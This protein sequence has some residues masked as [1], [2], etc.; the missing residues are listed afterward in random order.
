M[1]K[2]NQP[3]CEVAQLRRRS[4]C[5]FLLLMALFCVMI[6]RLYGISNGTELAAAAQAQQ[7]YT[8]AVANTRGTVFDCKLRPITNGCT[9]A[10]TVAAATPAAVTAVRSA[11]SAEAAADVLAR[12]QS[13]KPILFNGALPKNTEGACTFFVPQ[14]YT[15]YFCAPH[16][17]GYTNADGNGVCGVEQAYNALLTACGGSVTVRYRADAWGRMLNGEAL[18]STNTTQNGGGVV[19]TLDRDIQ[20]MAERVATEA[21]PRGAI[22]ILESA[23][24]KI[25]AM[26]STPAFDPQCVTDALQQKNAPLLNRALCA[27]NVGSVFK[28]VAASCAAES[29]ETTLKQ[30]CTGVLEHAGRTFQCINAV[31]HGTVGLSDAVAVSCNC[32]FIALAEQLGAQTVYDMAQR[33]GFGQSLWLTSNLVSENGVLPSLQDLSAPSALANFSFGQGDLLA[34]PLQ[35]AAMMQAIANDGQKIDPSL[36]EYTIDENGAVTPPQVLYAERV[37]SA[38]SAEL[39]RGYMQQAV[40]NGSAYRA[41]PAHGGAGAKTAT[42]ESGWYENGAAAVQAWCAGFYPSESAQYVI[43]VFAENGRS[44]SSA[45]APVFRQLADGLWTLGV[46]ENA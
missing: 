46:V 18:E 45:A 12:M 27:Y 8:L 9:R 26:V 28:L 37:M 34:T 14:Y 6:V 20:Q 19:L 22:V 10:V 40:T 36:V 5:G 35:I 41:A 25:R 11:L 17:L 21:L 32:Y 24:G 13:G 23:T 33:L 42:A 15:E 43:V 3:I 44:G 38:H 1:R 30:T 39:V 16:V 31:P 29:G 2:P 4:V 7:V